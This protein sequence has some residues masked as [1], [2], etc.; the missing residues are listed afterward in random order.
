MIASLCK[1]ASLKRLLHFLLKP[2]IT[3]GQK[4]L[5]MVG[6]QPLGKLDNCLDWN[7]WNQRFWLFLCLM[8]TWGAFNCL[9]F[10]RFVIRH[11]GHWQRNTWARLE[12]SSL[13]SHPSLDIL[14]YILGLKKPTRSKML[15]SRRRKI[16][17][18]HF[19]ILRQRASKCWPGAE[20]TWSSTYHPT[21]HQPTIHLWKG[22]VSTHYAGLDF[23]GR[24]IHFGQFR[25]IHLKIWI[26][27]LL[28]A[29]RVK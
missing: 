3:F 26:L 13:A 12:E 20:E 22:C 21:N 19:G 11:P 1:F 29:N 8:K 17:L 5:V 7:E 23:K 16:R 10:A 24:Q 28:T 2:V 14:I 15:F 18:L 9:E 27:W 4:L 6:V 25:Q